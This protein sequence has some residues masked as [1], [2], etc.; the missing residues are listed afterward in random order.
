MRVPLA[1]GTR[2]LT[3]GGRRVSLGRQRR[4]REVRGEGGVGVG[5]RCCEGGDV[6]GPVGRRRALAG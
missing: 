4:V 2:G 3:Q 1:V 5:K 6:A